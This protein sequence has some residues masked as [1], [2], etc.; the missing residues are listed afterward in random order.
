MPDLEP[1]APRLTRAP[2]LSP[3]LT[4][5]Q[6]AVLRT[7]FLPVR[8]GIPAAQRRCAPVHALALGN[9]ARTWEA[10]ATSECCE[11]RAR[12]FCPARCARRLKREL[13]PIGARVGTRT[14]VALRPRDDLR[15]SI[16]RHEAGAAHALWSDEIDLAVRVGDQAMYRGGR[17]N[18]HRCW[19]A[20]RGPRD[21]ELSWTANDRQQR[22]VHPTPSPSRARARTQEARRPRS[23]EQDQ[24]RSSGPRH[25]AYICAATTDTCRGLGP[26]GRCR[27]HTAETRG[28]QPPMSPPSRPSRAS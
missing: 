23:T 24:A 22:H 1:I 5:L 3:R 4:A 2:R 26:S 6:R 17:P 15:T 20:R 14:T 7:V 11:E 13:E 8:K 21:A 9:A 18:R 16:N 12:V 28:L 27:D 10:E 19:G 25:G